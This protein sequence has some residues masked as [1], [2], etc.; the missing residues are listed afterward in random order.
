[1]VAASSGGPLEIIEQGITGLLEDPTDDVAFSAAI[2]R[3]LEDPQLGQNIGTR[4]A[5]RARSHYSADRYARDMEAAFSALLAQPAAID[6]GRPRAE[7]RGGVT[8]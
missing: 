1:V 7:R 5:H 2:L 8:Q 3:I 6:D 4:A